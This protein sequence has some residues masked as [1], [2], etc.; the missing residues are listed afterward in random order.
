MQLFPPFKCPPPRL[1]FLS[2]FSLWPFVFYFIFCI[3]FLFQLSIQLD[4]LISISIARVCLGNKMPRIRS[5][6]LLALFFPPPY[7]FLSSFSKE[8]LHVDCAEAQT[9]PIDGIPTDYKSPG[10]RTN[11]PTIYTWRLYFR[12]SIARFFPSLPPLPLSFF[13]SFFL[14]EVY[15]LNPCDWW[16]R[17]AFKK[18]MQQTTRCANKTNTRSRPR[19]RTKQGSNPFYIEK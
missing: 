10:T 13:L 8:K 18:L 7:L 19:T 17:L 2:Y 3:S 12:S 6:C 1:F 4:L 14:K 15:G 11:R 16:W 9:V 5:C